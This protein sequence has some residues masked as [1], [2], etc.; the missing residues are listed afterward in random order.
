ML[1]DAHSPQAEGN[2]N[3]ETTGYKKVSPPDRIVKAGRALFFAHGFSRVS[4]VMLAKEASVSKAT[5]Y[6][7]FPNMVEVLKAVTEIEGRNFEPLDATEIRD[8]EHLEA[9]LVTFGAELMKFLN[10]PE[11]LQFTQL[12]H[13]EAR[14]YPEIAFEFYRSSYGRT[15]SILSSIFEQGIDRGFLKATLKPEELAEQLL[16]MWEGISFVRAQMGVTKRPFP[17]PEDRSRK[18]VATLLGTW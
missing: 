5:L 16:G 1:E 7:Y 11:I 2:N 15:L 4:T 13:E 17:K 14:A 10:K 8:G 12:M 3:I 9:I 18:C 6:K